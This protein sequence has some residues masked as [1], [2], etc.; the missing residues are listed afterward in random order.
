MKKQILS[1]QFQRMQ[2]LAG[3]I[4]ESPMTAGNAGIGTGSL[5]STKE[6]EFSEEILDTIKQKNL[7][8]GDKVQWMFS[9]SGWRDKTP[10]KYTGTFN[11]WALITDGGMIKPFNSVNI[12]SAY[13]IVAV[14]NSD[15]S[16]SKFSYLYYYING[17]PNSKD[18]QKAFE[19]LEKQK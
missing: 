17:N 14:V 5:S 12:K 2:K 11:R 10:V 3:I 6:N 18:D 4:T 1:E 13:G 19:T 7:Q 8:K 15:Q 9:F 16:P